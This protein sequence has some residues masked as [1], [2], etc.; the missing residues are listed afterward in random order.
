MKL[1]FINNRIIKGLRNLIA[2]PDNNGYH[3][4]VLLIQ[5]WLSMTVGA[6]GRPDFSRVRPAVFMLRRNDNKKVLHKAI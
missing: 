1:K 3:R 5:A 4:E 2:I 6:D